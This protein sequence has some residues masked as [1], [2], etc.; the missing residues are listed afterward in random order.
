MPGRSSTSGRRKAAA[1]RKAREPPLAEE[2]Q[3][4]ARVVAMLGNN[5]VRAK[6][7]DGSERQCRIRGSM[8]R[9]EW[10][11]VNDIV[12]VALR[13]DLAGEQADIVFK[14]QQA[15]VQRLRRLGEAVAIAADEEE[16]SME[17]L[18]AF[19]ALDDDSNNNC[20]AG[21]GRPRRL[22]M[23]PEDD[24]SEGDDD[25]DLEWERI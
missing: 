22:D 25:S 8:R 9:R 17:D 13:E 4:Y 16:A 1:Q 5:R 2:N 18:I 23:P 15:E 7:A 10:V 11:H 24:S 19:E 3:E 12:L 20:G 6:F 21:P 14:Y